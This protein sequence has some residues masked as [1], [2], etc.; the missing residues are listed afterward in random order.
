MLTAQGG[1][2]RL[3]W[4]SASFGCSVADVDKPLLSVAQVCASGGKVV[5]SPSGSYIEMKDGRKDQLEFK[6]GFLSQP[7]ANTSDRTTGIAAPQRA[8]EGAAKEGNRR[9]ASGAYGASAR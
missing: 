7:A 8:Q 4:C 3:C 6:K 2:Y 5:F 9:G 1:V